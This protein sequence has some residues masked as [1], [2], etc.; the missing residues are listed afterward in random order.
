[1]IFYVGLCGNGRARIPF[2]SSAGS[3]QE[4]AAEIYRKSM[5]TFRGITHAKITAVVDGTFKG[6]KLQL[7]GNGDIPAGWKII[8]GRSKEGYIEANSGNSW[9]ESY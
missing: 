7:V 2:K 9:T 5:E 1:M 8:N 6:W 4:A 3:P